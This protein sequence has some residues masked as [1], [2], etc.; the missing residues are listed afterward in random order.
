MLTRQ[1]ASH[2]QCRSSIHLAGIIFGRAFRSLRFGGL[3]IVR[4]EGGIFMPSIVGREV[5]FPAPVCP[6]STGIATLPAHARTD[7]CP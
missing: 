4:H 6:G 5:K 1:C 3:R 2:I 7:F